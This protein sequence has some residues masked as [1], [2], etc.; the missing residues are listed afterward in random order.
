MFVN[1][2]C[3]QSVD[4]TNKVFKVMS[5]RD[6]TW[7]KFEYGEL[8]DVVDLEEI[9]WPTNPSLAVRG[10]LVGLGVER[11]VTGAPGWGEGVQGE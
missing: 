6:A 9:I 3:F 2:N 1:S 7:K 10:E 5:T 4:I 8:V 11:E